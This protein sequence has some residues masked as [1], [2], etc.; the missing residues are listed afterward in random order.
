MDISEIKVSTRTIEIKHPKTGDNLG[1]RVTLKS[2]DDDTMTKTKRTITD[3][4]LYL[5]QRG[6]SFKAEEIEENKN[7]LLVAAMTD[8]EWYKPTDD[9][10]APTFHGETPAFNNRTIRAVFGELAWFR[11]QVSEELGESKAFFD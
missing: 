1:I 3:R 2:L 4:R 8:W 10:D 5:E 7:N 11:D 9:Q 6:K